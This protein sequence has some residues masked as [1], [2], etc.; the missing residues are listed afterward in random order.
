MTNV[1]DDRIASMLTEEVNSSRRN[2]DW[3]LVLGIV[4]IVAGILAAGYA[5]SETPASVVTLGVLLLVAAGAQI[6]AAMLA[7]DWIAFFLFLLLGVLN[8]VV[9]FLALREW[10]L[11]AEGLNVVLVAGYPIGSML[12][13]VI[14]SVEGF[15]S[16]N[17]ARLNG[18]ITMLLGVAIWGPWPECNL[19]ALGLLIGID[20]VV[21]GAIWSVL[22][23]GVHTLARL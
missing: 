10:L 6:A 23:V 9:G 15:P 1:A 8:A 21:N 17:W 20:L 13:V 11:G 12:R 16:W 22:A 14:A 3:I 2:W 5:L 4:Q 7:R 18:A 19:W